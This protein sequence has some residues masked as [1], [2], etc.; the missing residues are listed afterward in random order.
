MDVVFDMD[1]FALRGDI[2][3][4]ITSKIEIKLFEQFELISC[5]EL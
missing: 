4:Q 3:W 1:V 5:N 2:M